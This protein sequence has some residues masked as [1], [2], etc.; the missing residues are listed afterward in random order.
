MQKTEKKIKN[1]TAY[2][3]RFEKTTVRYV[4][5]DETKA[6]FMLL[7]P[8][9]KI[10][11]VYDDYCTKHA[12]GDYP[13]HRDW[14]AG[15]LVHFHLRGDVNPSYANSMKFGEGVKKLKFRSQECS[16]QDGYVVINTTVETDEGYGAI[17]SLKHTDGENGFEVKNTFFNNSGNMLT[18]ELLSSATL[19]NISPYC[20][21]DSSDKCYLHYFRGGWAIEGKHVKTA[22]SK[23]SMEKSWG[24]SFENEIFSVAGSKSVQ[25]YYPYFAFEDEKNNTIWGIKLRHNTSWQ[26]EL[27]RYGEKLSLSM[28]IA[29]VNN[30][31]WFKN[32]E[33]GETFETPVAYIATAEGGIAE[34]SD[35]F[36]KIQLRD[37][38]EYLE[39]GLP[40]YF[41]EWCTTW[42]DPTEESMLKLANVLKEHKSEVKYL[43]IDAGWNGGITGDWEYEKERF[44]NGLKSY[45]DKIRSMG[46][47][48]GIWMEYECI[49]ANAK[50]FASEYDKRYLT[51]YG[52]VIR[53]CVNNSFP[54]KYLDLSKDEVQ[55]YLTETVIKFLKDNGFGYLKIDYNSNIGIG[56]DGAESLGEGLRQH[57]ERVRAFV[58]RI[59]KEI[60][61]IIIE[62]CSS[63]GCRHD[64]DTVA[65][66]SVSSFSDAH[67]SFEIPA[68]AANLNYIIPPSKC[69]V[70]S[71]LRKNFSE[72]HMKYI[73]SSTFLGRLCWSG[74]FAEL[75]EWQWDMVIKAEKMYKKVSDIIKDGYSEIFRTNEHNYRY[76]EG[77]QA[78]I[79]YS[80]DKSKAIVVYH[81]FENAKELQIE[82]KENMKI[83]EKLF[84]DSTVI[85]DGKMVID[86]SVNCIGNII[87]IEKI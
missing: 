28:G 57:M 14:F 46:F 15:T 48:P 30:G 64:P 45:T 65:I 81:C 24:G 21:E 71:T 40:I 70:W 74:D 83:T 5:M 69:Q 22:V 59:K 80:E 76:L 38:D 67:E 50:R 41:N 72:K 79:R 85:K 1:Y 35:I 29:D 49:G 19:D 84:D 3:Y 18:L 47:I 23:M 43:I 20:E 32:V 13:D 87:L 31:A 54:H 33:N 56:C 39:D 27:T 9:G 11:D 8:N 10:D 25:R 61:D 78:V 36:L 77:S 52:K 62:N 60:P 37:C 26:A 7:I 44:P 53:G 82:L 2:D 42:G 17:H 6:V 34:L 16:E 58:R 68:V 63:G 75:E 73:I 12:P 66:T 51:Q 86:T 4:V 55:N